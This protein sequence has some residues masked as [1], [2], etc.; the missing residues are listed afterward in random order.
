MIYIVLY[1]EEEVCFLGRFGVDKILGRMGM[2]GFIN[3]KN[4]LI[5]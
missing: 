3:F 4:V 5:L 2:G 1:T